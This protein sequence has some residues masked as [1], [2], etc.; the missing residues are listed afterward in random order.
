MNDHT[1][2][3]RIKTMSRVLGVSR[4]GF[5]AWRARQGSPSARDRW[6]EQLDQRVAGA[7]VA[8][9]GRNGSPRLKRDLAD[10]GH[11]Y[12][13]KT[14]A[15]SLQRQGL[16]A[17][18]AKKFQATTHSNHNLRGGAESPWTGFYGHGPQPEVGGRHHLSCAQSSEALWTG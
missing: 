18:A 13:R 2:M 10:D 14:I 15:T 12:D 11:P 4:S 3:F 7:F 5:Y 8:S 16:R 9:K 1:K 6:R 17:K